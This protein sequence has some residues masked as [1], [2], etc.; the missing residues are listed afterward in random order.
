MYSDY[1]TV[2]VFFKDKNGY[3][4]LSKSINGGLSWEENTLAG[5]KGDITKIV[6]DPLNK[7]NIYILGSYSIGSRNIPIIYKSTDKGE[8]WHSILDINTERKLKALNFADNVYF[9]NDFLVIQE[10]KTENELS[11]RNFCIF[12][13]VFDPSDNKSIYVSTSAGLIK[14]ADSGKTWH[15]VN[16]LPFTKLFLSDKK[17]LYG[18][19]SREVKKSYD[20]GKNWVVVFS[21]ENTRLFSIK[22]LSGNNITNKLYISTSN[23]LKIID[24][25][26]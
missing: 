18:V 15:A 5:R 2:I 24:F 21:G 20:Y 13:M 26:K 22:S 25:E 6:I 16:N 12:D 3:L 9:R 7:T 11:L 10:K 23:G 14:S 1:N 8:I 4:E 19:H 17:V